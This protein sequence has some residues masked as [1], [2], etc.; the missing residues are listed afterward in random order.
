MKKY[1][2]PLA[3]ALVVLLSLA[4]PFAVF[5]FRCG[6][7]HFSPPR[8]ARRPPRGL[9]AEARANSTACTLYACSH[10]LN[11]PLGYNSGSETPGRRPPSM[12]PRWAVLA[13]PCAPFTMLGC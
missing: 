6:T 7:K 8:T 2:L 1:R 4:L 11:V 3:C 13:A 10:V 9:S 5:F 12:T